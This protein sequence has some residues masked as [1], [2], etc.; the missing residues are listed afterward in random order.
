M[1]SSTHAPCLRPSRNNNFNVDLRFAPRARSIG[2]FKHWHGQRQ[3]IV[4]ARDV[5]GS[6][7]LGGDSES[8]VEALDMENLEVSIT[9][10]SYRREVIVQERG[11]NHRDSPQFPR[12]PGAQ[13]PTHS[14]RFPN[15]LRNKH[16]LSLNSHVYAFTKMVSNS[17]AH[18]QCPSSAKSA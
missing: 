3:S 1:P 13:P 2:S 16:N 12:P 10:S 7:M 17:S 15:S 5:S 11:H 8:P 14:H 4:H 9:T 18:S 6:L